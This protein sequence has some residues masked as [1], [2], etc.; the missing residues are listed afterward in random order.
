MDSLFWITA[1]SA[2]VIGIFLLSI[3]YDG[4]MDEGSYRKIRL[5]LALGTFLDALICL[6]SGICT[7]YGA[8]PIVLDQHFIPIIFNVQLSAM[9]YAMMG[10]LHLRHIARYTPLMYIISAIVATVT[11]FVSYWI[12][13]DGIFSWERYVDFTAN[14][15]FI[16]WFRV[17]YVLYLVMA[18]VRTCVYLIRA[19]HRYIHIVENYFSEE[20]VISGRRLSGSV[21]IFVIYFLCS[22]FVFLIPNVL[23]NQLIDLCI[24]ACLMTFAIMIINL[25]NTYFK[26][27]PPHNLAEM[28]KSLEERKNGITAECESTAVEKDNIENEPTLVR[29]SIE[30]IVVGWSQREDKPYAKESLTLLDVAKAT[31]LSPRLLSE[32]LNK[33]YK[34]NFCTWINT[35]RINEVKRLLVEQPNLTIAEISLMVGFSD[36][37][38]L[39][40]TFKKIVNESPSTY[41]KHLSMK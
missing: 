32:F 40:K 29:S 38:A 30:D 37:A 24:T 11:V 13:S 27:Y 33:Y 34:V 20:E 35:L 6:A 39:S 16:H 23:I 15:N 26:I 41:R 17:V 4:H 8:D 7:R 19:S 2:I 1:I 36:P 28:L 9:A 12:W 18:L 3:R 21:Y 14:C 10:L 31:K 25:H 5:L 22:A